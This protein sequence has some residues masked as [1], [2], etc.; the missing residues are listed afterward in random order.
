MDLMHH[1]VLIY[2]QG[3]VM[4]FLAFRTVSR[5]CYG[6]NTQLPVLRPI[7]SDWP[8][9]GMQVSDKV[10]PLVETILLAS[11]PVLVSS[12]AASSAICGA[13][14][15]G[16]LICVPSWLL[17]AAATMYGY[18]GRQIA[19]KFSEHFFEHYQRDDQ[20]KIAGALAPWLAFVDVSPAKLLAKNI[21]FMLDIGIL[22]FVPA[23][24][25]LHLS[26]TCGA[27]I[28]ALFTCYTSIGAKDPRLLCNVVLHIPIAVALPRLFAGFFTFLALSDFSRMAIKIPFYAAASMDELYQTYCR[29]LQATLLDNVDATPFGMLS[30][31]RRTLT[32]LR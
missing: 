5:G 29:P 10:G 21:V 17:K 9:V 30:E 4:D 23:F 1:H 31:S 13:I 20:L 19:E 32:T 16:A 3:N 8:S 6:L 2:L 11:I 18:S 12:A 22:G 25:S 28:G 26:V 7:K 27:A 15:A 24:G 14:A